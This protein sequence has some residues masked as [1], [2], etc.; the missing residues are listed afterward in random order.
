VRSKLDSDGVSLADGA[1]SPWSFDR[2]LIEVWAEAR[3]YDKTIQRL[4]FSG[5]EA[6]SPEK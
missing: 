6:I 2:F 4:S 1:D 3:R 5:I